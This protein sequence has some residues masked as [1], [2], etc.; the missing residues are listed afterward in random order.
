MATAHLCLRRTYDHVKPLVA[1]K[2]TP[3][4]L[5][6]ISAPMQLLHTH[7]LPICSMEIG[8]RIPLAHPQLQVGED[9]A[10]RTQ[11][12][13]GEPWERTTRPKLA[14]TRARPVLRGQASQVPSERY[15]RGPDRRPRPSD[16]AVLVHSLVHALRH[17]AG[18]RKSPS[19]DDYESHRTARGVSAG[20]VT[21]TLRQKGL[22]WSRQTTGIFG[23]DTQRIQ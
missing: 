6:A 2:P 1:A 23:T 18:H 5:V 19:S 13:R 17:T 9:D 15:C 11:R 8:V 3:P 16:P 4:A 20:I 12:H 10:L 14:H 21:A 7:T 22:S